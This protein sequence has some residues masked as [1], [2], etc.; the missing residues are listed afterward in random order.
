MP[1]PFRRTYT[2]EW[3]GGGDLAGVHA[4]SRPYHALCPEGVN[5]RQRAGLRRLP[6]LRPMRSVLPPP[7]VSGLCRQEGRGP[8]ARRSADGGTG[9]PLSVPRSGPRA[10]IDLP[11]PDGRPAPS[12]SPRPGPR[13][14]GP[15]PGVGASSDTRRRSPPVSTPA[16]GTRLGAARRSAGDAGREH[17]G[18]FG[19]AGPGSEPRR[20]PPLSGARPPRPE[21][22]V[23][24]ARAPPTHRPHGLLLGPYAPAVRTA[25]G[26]CVLSAP[27][28]RERS[29]CLSD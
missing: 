27:I 21:P 17:P 14:G 5:T 16:A 28:R 11:P 25:K 1:P 7:P 22:C 13:A 9:L 23:L 19:R 24:S 10:L 2:L 12:P 6:L 18:A 20:S 15:R 4:S 29:D 26:L 3:G 8:A